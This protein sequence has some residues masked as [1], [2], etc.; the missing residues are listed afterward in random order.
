MY[1]LAIIGGGPAGTAAGVYAARKRLKT[2]FIAEAIGGQSIDSQ[3]IQNWIGTTHI[4]G[5]ELQ[6]ALEKHLKEYAGDV[7]EIKLGTRATKVS[8]IAGGFSVEAGQT[9][10]ARAVLVATG[11]V[12]RTLDIPGAREFENKGLTYCASCDGPLFSGQDVAVVGG[13]NAG[14]ETAA[15]LL[16]Y[17][18]SVTLIHRG[19][20]CTKADKATVDAVTAHP[21]MKVL[22]SSVP[23]EM[24]GGP[25]VKG[26]VVKNVDTGAQ[27]EL[28]VTGIFVEIGMVPATGLVTGLVQL[29]EWGRIKVDGKS[30]R[31]S[32]EGV[33]AAGDCTDELYHQNN[34]AAGD[35]VKALEDA[36]FWIKSQPVVSSAPSPA[37]A[38][39]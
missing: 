37:R 23:V 17:C 34:I 8:K 27:T 10:Q 36:Y 25:F 33:W 38:L 6:S 24:R 15:Q 29:D 20:T 26:L 18:K 32:A 11:G 1:D 28:P 7:L 2:I 9:Y 5:L 39:S 3:D 21:N 19:P 13:G 14:F 31:T 35:A 30:Q 22:T 16:A 12:R 4:A